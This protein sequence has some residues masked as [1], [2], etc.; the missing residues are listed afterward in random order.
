MDNMSIDQL[1]KIS[2]DHKNMIKT[3]T[4]EPNKQTHIIKPIP[5]IKS[6]SPEPLLKKMRL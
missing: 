6:I 2:T 1:T 4:P 5:I 3:I